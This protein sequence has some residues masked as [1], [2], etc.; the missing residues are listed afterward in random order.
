MH[1]AFCYGHANTSFQPAHVFC[2]FGSLATLPLI[3][4]HNILSISSHF[5]NFFKNKTKFHFLQLQ[6]HALFRVQNDQWCNNYGGQIPPLNGMVTSNR[7]SKYFFQSYNKKI[8][9]R[10]FLL[11]FC[12]I[13]IQENEVCWIIQHQCLTNFFNYMSSLMLKISLQSKF[14]P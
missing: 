4:M 1:G 10:T 11:M 3:L 7:V 9:I 8:Q 6:L 12:W 14:H 13:F 2:M 5:F